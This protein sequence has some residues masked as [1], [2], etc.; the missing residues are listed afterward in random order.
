MPALFSIIKLILL[1]EGEST[2]LTAEEQVKLNDLRHDSMMLREKI[3]NL[4]N[5]IEDCEYMIANLDK[6]KSGR[7][8]GFVFMLILTIIGFAIEWFYINIQG[9]AMGAGI[10]TKAAALEFA[11]SS[12]SLAFFTTV[13]LALGCFTMFLGIKLML[14][15]GTSMGSRRLAEALGVKNYSNYVEDKKRKYNSY[16]KKMQSMV[17]EKSRIDSEISEMAKEESPWNPLG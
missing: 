8:V 16:E 3:Y 6:W 12:T 11:V 15:T 2:M 17:R 5:D 10:Q 13:L 1:C 14:E 9:N 7:W 4:Q